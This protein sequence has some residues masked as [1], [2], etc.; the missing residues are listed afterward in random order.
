MLCVTFIDRSAA[1]GC[2]FLEAARRLVHDVPGVT[3]RFRATDV[4]RLAREPAAGAHLVFV[5]PAN[6]MGFMDG[7]IDAVYCEMFPGVQRR[8]RWRIAAT[9]RV[10][11]LGRPY[12]SVGGALLVP[13]ND[14]GNDSGSDSGSV[15]LASAPTMF[16]PHGVSRTRNAYHAMMAALCV[17]RKRFGGDA[18][19]ELVCPPLCCGWGKM[20]PEE[21]AAQVATA[22]ADFA[23]GRVPQDAAPPAEADRFAPA[24]WRERDAEQ[25]RNF[26]NREIHGDHHAVQEI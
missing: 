8:V 24:D 23:A 2:G 6:G 26:D 20:A 4:Q 12:Q 16:L 17:V 25:P 7:G 5:S 18:A 10:T 14:S 11:L 15:W 13:G 21:A 22:L 3:V 9:G 1:G 19:V